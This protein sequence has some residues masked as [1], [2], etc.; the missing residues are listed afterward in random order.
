[1]NNEVFERGQ[2]IKKSLATID[3]IAEMIKDRS[4][5]LVIVLNPFDRDK[6]NCRIETTTSNVDLDLFQNLIDKF[7]K[8]LRNQIPEL[9]KHLE[10][11]FRNL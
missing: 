9:K 11:E 5:R 10:V 7:E 2:A 3:H 6:S 1:M 8:D 4:C